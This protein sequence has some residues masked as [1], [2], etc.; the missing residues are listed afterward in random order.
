MAKAKTKTKKPTPKAPPKKKPGAKPPA[1]AKK[2][3]G[4]K[5]PALET[6][7]AAPKP[8][9]V[10]K[11][12]TTVPVASGDILAAS[13]AVPF[14]LEVRQADGSVATHQPDQVD[15][16]S[17]PDWMAVV[18]VTPCARRY[19]FLIQIYDD[20][21]KFAMLPMID[22][23]G[24]PRLPAAG[25]WFRPIVHGPLHL[26]GSDRLLTRRDIA[27]IIG[28]HAGKPGETVPPNI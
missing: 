15:E 7:A 19:L 23:A 17:P 1:S 4:A 10:P 8:T 12:P 6:K 22:G 18:P 16:V 2:K 26:I 28:G 13:E 3:A 21:R 27:G 11:K 9:Q 24:A 20:D 25:G 14:R 5:P